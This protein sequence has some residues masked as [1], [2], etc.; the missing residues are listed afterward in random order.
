M[1]MHEKVLCKIRI[2]REKSRAN[3]ELGVKQTKEKL[4]IYTITVNKDE[5][6]MFK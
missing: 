3:Y 4:T 5:K 2:K 6:C 1:E